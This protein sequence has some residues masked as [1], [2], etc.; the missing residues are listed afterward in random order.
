MSCCGGNGDG[1]KITK[2]KIIIFSSLGA[3]IATASYFALTTTNSQALVASSTLLG[4]AACPAMC[5]VMGGG[6]WIFNKLSSKKKRN[7]VYENDN[8]GTNTNQKIKTREDSCCSVHDSNE[9]H[10]K[11]VLKNPEVSIPTILKKKT[12]SKDKKS[13]HTTL[14]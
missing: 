9:N 12:R 4:F 1:R 6:I 13:D 11:E 7:H 14:E 8:N 5:A 3:G 2:K 10:G